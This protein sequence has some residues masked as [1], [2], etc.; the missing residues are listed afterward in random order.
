[1]SAPRAMA[2]EIIVR[3]QYPDAGLDLLR[4]H[5]TVHYAP[6]PEAFEAA[7]DASGGVV[8]GLVTNGSLGVSA[9]QIAR[10]PKLEVIH[11]QGVGHE[12]VDL[13]A[14]R[15]QGI[16]VATNKGTNSFSVADHAMALL[17]SVA[18]GIPWMDREVRA[19]R[20]VTARKSRPLAYRKRLGILGLGEIG[21]MVAQRA[22]GFEM[23][24]GYH[25]RNPRDDVPHVYHASPLALA[26]AS[27]FVVVSM[28]GGA[29]TRK[30]VNAAFL[31]ALGP[32]GF[33]INIGRGSSVDNDDLAA[34]LTE[35]RIAGAAIDVVDGEPEV[36]ASLLAAP[37]LIITP[38]I[39][40]R[41]PESVNSAN[42]RVADNLQAYFAGEPMV[43]QIL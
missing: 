38:H 26:A 4:A 12:N 10:M 14:A 27:D 11:T 29:G 17:L 18:R 25:N 9:S 8:R 5:F 42:A 19:G 23:E 3:I 24:I 33:L 1:M 2:P 20:W 39:A 6:S 30:V 22:A 16:R 13:D 15:A 28:P 7:I 34:A 21:M 40:S 32:G 35:G 43:S 41:S 36:P 31:D 37:N